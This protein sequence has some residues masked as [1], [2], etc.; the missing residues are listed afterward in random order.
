MILLSVLMEE[1]RSMVGQQIEKKRRV[2]DEPIDS[3]QRISIFTLIC[4]DLTKTK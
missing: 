2:A 4:Y 1:I 3:P